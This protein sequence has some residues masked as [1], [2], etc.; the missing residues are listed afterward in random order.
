GRSRIARTT[1]S[2]KSGSAS[3]A[4]TRTRPP[5]LARSPS[6]SKI[7]ELY[8]QKSFFALRLLTMSR[9]SLELH[10]HDGG[11]DALLAGGL[12]ALPAVRGD[13]LD[14]AD[15]RGQEL[16]DSPPTLRVEHDVVVREVAVGAVLERPG[17]ERRAHVLE[18]DLERR[19]R[20]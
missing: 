3:A 14:V 20:D 15:H 10:C 8:Q 12:E 1:A 5:G 7:H 13:L 17:L 16:S 18:D 11:G 9:R 19:V 6:L 4:R 2:L